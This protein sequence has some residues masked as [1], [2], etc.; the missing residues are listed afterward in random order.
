MIAL[1]WSFLGTGVGR[2]VGGVLGTAVLMVGLYA[3]NAITEWRVSR[4]YQNGARVVVEA[5]KRRDATVAELERR[6]ERDAAELE[7]MRHKIEGTR[8][9]AGAAA[10]WTARLDRVLDAARAPRR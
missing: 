6:A 3:W 2:V 8:D 9:H 5:V 7:A 1:I 4:A 10:D